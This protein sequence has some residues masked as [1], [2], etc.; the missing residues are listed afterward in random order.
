MGKRQQNARVTENIG[1]SG[2]LINS[3][4]TDPIKIFKYL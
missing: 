4:G 3:A 2:N 1:Q